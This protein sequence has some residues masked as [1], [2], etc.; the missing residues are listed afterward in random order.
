[1]GMNRGIR[2]TVAAALALAVAAGASGCTEV[3]SIYSDAV[4]TTELDGL[5]RELGELDGVTVKHSSSIQPDYTYSVTVEVE[6]DDPQPQTLRTVIERSVETLGGGVLLDQQS[7]FRVMSGDEWL[8]ASDNLAAHQSLG[9][10][11]RDDL[12][13]WLALREAS[14]APLSLAFYGND[15]APNGRTRAI[16]SSEPVD[17]A[18]LRAIDD[19]NDVLTEWNFQAL[20]AYGTL[21]SEEHVE[22]LDELTAV[23]P[24]ADDV[25]PGVGLSISGPITRV[26]VSGAEP[27]GD[28]P[29]TESATWSQTIAIARIAADRTDALMYIDSS[30]EAAA[31]IHFGECAEQSPITP[32]DSIFFDALAAERVTMPVG[33]GPGYCNNGLI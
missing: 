16:S 19:P 14:G 20:Y 3:T 30:W 1:M 28:R 18:S 4:I 8:F 15:A 23:L 7:A 9:D 12:D 6:I 11:V 10:V 13:Y 17:I 27:T 29:V 31:S 33:S 21:P 24:P 25:H 22:L 26:Q 5:A 2:I 32:A